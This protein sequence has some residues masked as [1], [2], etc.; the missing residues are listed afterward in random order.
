MTQ[1]VR[2]SLKNNPYNIL[3]GHGLISRAGA[4]LKKL[5]VG[6]NALVVTNKSLARLYGKKLKDSLSKSGID[7][8]ILLTP[9]SEKAKSDR[10]FI[11]LLNKMGSCD[12]NKMPFL[13]A[14]GGGVVGDLTGFAASVYKRGVPYIQIP[15]T[16][17]SQ[18]DS[19]IG[20][21]TAI[22]LPAA[23]NLAGTFYQPRV[24]ISDT[25]LLKSLPARQIRSGLAECIKYGVIKD[26]G[27][28]EYLEKNYK[29]ALALDK[30]ALRHIISRCSR[31]KATVV[32]SDEFDKK[33]KRIILNYGHTIGHAIE[34]ACGY[35]PRY[36]HGEAIAIGML[37]ASRISSKLGILKWH[38]VSR[39]ESL[40]KKCGLPAKIRGLKL[41][42]IYNA[43]LR[44]KKFV[45]GKN[46]L[47]LPVRIGKASV[48]E[49]V[50]RSV[51]IDSIK[52]S[53]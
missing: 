32:A 27:L 42:R 46:R 33:N 12:R 44:D 31:I 8:K 36:S 51:I 38:D 20:G 29:K 13:V 52:V 43:L 18:V 11:S 40:I 15:T 53:M 24:V 9:D 50:K 47:V 26:S 3:I 16:L 34:S 17:L 30:D 37:C 14:L 23:K 48:V 7:C 21:K 4:I 49:G 1:S 19:A 45:S 28:F 35:S 22:D 41:Q 39:I 2:V 6:K 25:S 5:P 10:V